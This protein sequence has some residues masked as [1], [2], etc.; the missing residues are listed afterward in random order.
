MASTTTA[1]DAPLETI[2]A[3][4]AAFDSFL[5]GFDDGKDPAPVSDEERAGL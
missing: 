3:K 1:G 4:A 5:R 2:L